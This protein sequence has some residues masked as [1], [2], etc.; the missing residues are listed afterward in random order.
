M[1]SIGKLNYQLGLDTSE[2]EE[3][4][5]RTATE[6]R[7]MRQILREI[8][9]PAEKYEKK[10]TDIRNA[11]RKGHISADQARR[12]LDR[13]HDEMK[14][15][16][17]SASPLVGQ[18]KGM[19]P[20]FISLH[21]AAMAAAAG[22]AAFTLGLRGLQTAVME[23]AREFPLIDQT[24]KVS[25][26]L[27][28]A[29]E[30]LIGFRLA[31]AEMSGVEAGVVDMALQ[32][33][34]RRI[35]EAANGFG[36]AK[37][38][39][40][41]LGLSATALNRDPASAF[42]QIANAMLRVENQTDRVRLAQKLFDSEG[43][44]LVNTLQSGSGALDAYVQRA[45]ELG[46]AFDA[47]EA[48]AIEE[49]NDSLGELG[50]HLKGIKTQLAV[51]FAP[52]ISDALALILAGLDSIENK[53]GK[54]IT[55]LQIAARAAGQFAPQ[56]LL[57]SIAQPA[58]TIATQAAG[59]GVGAAT[60]PFFE[61][62]QRERDLD[63]QLEERRRAREGAKGP[64]EE[65]EIFQPFGPKE[66]SQ[67]FETMLDAMASEYEREQK[68]REQHNNRMEELQKAEREARAKQLEQIDADIAHARQAEGER[69]EHNKRVKA[70][71]DLDILLEAGTQRAR[72]MEL[73]A[74]GFGPKKEVQ[75][76][77][78]ADDQLQRLIEERETFVEMED[79]VR[80]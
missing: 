21:P 60:S 40:E 3:G 80:V 61:Q 1:V 26:R 64:A 58:G 69:L 6:T 36:E 11:Y 42:R 67:A 16:T 62:R 37:A 14:E 46:I 54:V 70:S 5:R 57:P 39:I 72:T 18:L 10:W 33:M 53:S 13:L 25:E 68:Q 9:T 51:E 28:I 41:E 15:G 65:I 76:V 45:E 24:A 73:R 49:V 7:K 27:G 29:T 43:V 30:E 12:A 8:Q 20:S 23:I 66:E 22:I 2:F 78:I 38:A 44:A 17:R 35:A 4:T 32:R 77:R 56:A 31:A 63:R 71:R 79:D 52:A 34:T 59:M 55:A 47:L 48:D 75:K 19:A 74:R 50:M